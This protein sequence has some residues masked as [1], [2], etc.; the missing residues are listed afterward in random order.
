[1]RLDTDT[2]DLLDTN[3]VACRERDRTRIANKKKQSFMNW[4]QINKKI[5]SKDL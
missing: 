3:D 2:R 5:F 1:M 4:I